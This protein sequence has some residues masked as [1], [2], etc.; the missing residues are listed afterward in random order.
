[1]LRVDSIK[2][3]RN[4][5]HRQSLCS[6][7]VCLM[8]TGKEMMGMRTNLKI[9]EE[10]LSVKLVRTVFCSLIPTMGWD[11]LFG[12]RKEGEMHTNLKGKEGANASV[13]LAMSYHKN[14]YHNATLPVSK[15]LIPFKLT[16]NA[17]ELPAF[18]K[19]KFKH[20]SSYLCLIATKENYM[21]GYKKVSLPFPTGKIVY[22]LSSNSLYLK[23]LRV[24]VVYSQNG[25][26]IL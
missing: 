21:S 3:C 26:T 17:H 22:Y 10:S 1:M 23:Y 14:M 6:V 15:S 9:S 7:M 12:F 24:R 25:S 4:Y 19:C 8:L 13:R 5:R 18:K 16:I 20:C 11:S 2:Q